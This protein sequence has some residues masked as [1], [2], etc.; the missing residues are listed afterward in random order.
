MNT[1]FDYIGYV[2]GKQDVRNRRFWT[3]NLVTIRKIR[4][5]FCPKMTLHD[6]I[7]TLTDQS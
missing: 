5:D 4:M 6:I 1:F 2:I 7:K 3:K